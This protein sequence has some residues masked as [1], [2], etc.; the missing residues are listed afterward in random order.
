MKNSSDDV[1][2][3]S[4]SEDVTKWDMPSIDQFKGENLSSKSGP[5]TQSEI[6]KIK[7]TA[8]QEA[9]AEAEAQAAKE[10]DALKQELSDKIS[11]VDEVITILHEPFSQLN[12]TVSEVLS[13]LAVSVAKN[14]VRRELSIN[15]DEII[16]V[17]NAALKELPA[18]ATSIILELHP[19]DYKIFQSIYC[20]IDFTSKGIKVHENPSIIRGG[21][22]F[23][24]DDFL[25]DETLD[26]R[27][28]KVTAK[29]LSDDRKNV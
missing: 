13:K 24:S 22:Q 12:D 17:I 16:G 9:L 20:D 15:P 11:H 29:M 19:E 7:M 4:P 10:I 21:C 18:T 8:Y 14:I 3:L 27:F 1:K 25:L 26:N 5:L 6:E 23:V 2:E 28:N